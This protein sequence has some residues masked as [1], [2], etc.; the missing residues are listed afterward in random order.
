VLIALSSIG[1]KGATLKD[2]DEPGHPQNRD[3]QSRAC[4]VRTG[5]AA[6]LQ[7]AGLWDAIRPKL[8]YGENVQQAVQFVESGSAEAGLVARS[9]AGRPNLIF[10]EVA[11]SLYAP[12]NQTAVVL[13]RS[14]QPALAASFLDFVKGARG[15]AAL[16]AFGFLVP[17]EDF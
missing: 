14:K 11:P 12:L 10:T 13:A 6:A 4:S 2:L 9:L 16:K 7:A 8:V 17:G 3:R 5:G 1:R 15:R